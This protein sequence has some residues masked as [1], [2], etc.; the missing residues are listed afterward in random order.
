MLLHADTQQEIR[1]PNQ[2]VLKDYTGFSCR[3]FNTNFLQPLVCMFIYVYVY[4][5]ILY[6]QISKYISEYMH[7]YIHMCV[8]MYACTYIYIYVYVCTRM[9]IHTD[10][11]TYTYIHVYIYIYIYIYICS[12]KRPAHYIGWLGRARLPLGAQPPGAL[13]GGLQLRP[14]GGEL[15]CCD[16]AVSIN[17]G[18]FLWLSLNAEP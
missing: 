17:L 18:S 4:I 14:V 11:H 5:Y 7:I 2:T 10:V 1:N 6:I 12:Y 15:S 3:A 13:V 8:C 9:C 16:V